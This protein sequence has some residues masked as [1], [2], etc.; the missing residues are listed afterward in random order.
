[1]A[2]DINATEDQ[3]KELHDELKGYEAHLSEY[4]STDAAQNDPNYPLLVNADSDLNIQIA[5][6]SIQN[7]KLTGDNAQAA[8]DS[9]NVAISNLKAAVA[10]KNKIAADLGVAQSAVSFVTALVSGNLSNIANTGKD[11][12]SKFK[13]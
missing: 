7:L 5:N 6:L 3:I 2:I 13:A 10:S 11:L 4:L 9:I 12:V 8:V 1:M